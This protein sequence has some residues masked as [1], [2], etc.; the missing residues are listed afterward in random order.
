MQMR[1]ITY[2]REQINRGGQRSSTLLTNDKGD[3]QIRNLLA[4]IHGAIVLTT[5]QRKHQLQLSSSTTSE[6]LPQLHLILSCPS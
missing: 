5:C 3:E 1:H 4:R 6:L 2:V